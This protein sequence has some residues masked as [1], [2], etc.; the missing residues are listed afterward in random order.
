MAWHLDVITR[1]GCFSAA[2]EPEP[3]KFGII[4]PLTGERDAYGQS[5][6]TGMQARAKQINAQGG[7]LGRPLVFEVLDTESSI[8]RAAEATAELARRP[9]VLVIL[10]P[11][12]SGEFA[13]MLNPAREGKIAVI[14]PKAT[15]NGITRDNPWAFRITFSNGF[16]GMAMA[17]FLIEKRNL[18]RFALFTDKRHGYTTD[19]SEDFRNTVTARGAEI[20]ADLFF[21]ND[22]DDDQTDYGPALRKIADA[23]PEALFI[24]AYT[25]EVQAIVRQADKI[26]LE[27]VVLCGGDSWDI[28]SVFQGS[29]FRLAGSYYIAN[30]S[31]V[32]DDPAISAFTESMREAGMDV[33]DSAA[34]LGY[35]AVTV[36]VLALERAK[37]PTRQGL[38][39]ALLTLTDVPL[40]TG[41]TTITPE[42][43]A[44][45]S[46]HIMGVVR[47]GDRLSAVEV[48]RLDP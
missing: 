10:G 34:A 11:H 43:E 36:A 35:D 32:S 46:V 23:N 29:G 48:E 13:A 17:R 37:E 20:V 22:D 21:P 28:E 31:I 33:P 24:S 7:V 2:A 18:K 15:Q 16:Q 30:F 41:K 39:D 14:A 8:K 6:L 4:I 27:E 26:A 19:L 47:E 45:K 9:E 44:I 40:I 3:V 12:T 1:I 5:F 38:R 25:D 42:G